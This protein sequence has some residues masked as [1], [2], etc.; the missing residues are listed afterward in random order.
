MNNILLIVAGEKD[1][2][3]PF[4]KEGK[5]LGLKVSTASFS[6]LNF[7]LEEGNHEFILKVGRKDV[8][9]FNL[10]YIR[11]VGKRLEEA[12]LL[13]NYAREKGIKVVDSLY[14]TQHLMPSSISKAL[15]TLLL[16][17]AKVPIPKTFFASLRYIKEKGGRLLGFPFVIKSTSGRK[18]R[19]V[20]S[21]QNQE[22]LDG[23]CKIL[24]TR[25]K[26][27][28]HFF[29]QKFIKASQRIR[30]LVVGEKIVGAI[31][32]PTKWRKRFVAKVNRE[33]PEGEKGAVNKVPFELS[34]LALK[35]ARAV[36][37]EIA[38]ID[39]LVDDFSGKAYVIEVNAAPS[40][41]LIEKDTGVNIE[42]V[43]MSFLKEI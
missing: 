20:W 33:V 26:A 41:K 39:I 15:E 21:P 8:S 7:L 32:R 5:K 27:G 13:A 25:E 16:T 2:L 30:I 42:N 22:E 10:V 37:L 24:E 4:V 11:L 23:L 43:I 28:E 3:K 1:R 6:D 34:N 35:A 29:A 19:D 31:T 36:S 14:E 9:E 12:S 40:W 38:G 17:K 18:A